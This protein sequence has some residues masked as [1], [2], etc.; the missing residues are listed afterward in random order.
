MGK[1]C[2]SPRPPPPCSPAASLVSRRSVV[3]D[4]ARD[5]LGTMSASAEI[6][7]RRGLIRSARVV[8][9]TPLYPI[10]MADHVARLQ[11]LVKRGARRSYKGAGTVLQMTEMRFR[12]FAS[13]DHVAG[14]GK[15]G[16]AGMEGGMDARLLLDFW[17]K[18][19]APPQQQQQQQQQ[20]FDRCVMRAYV[21]ENV[22]AQQF[23]AGQVQQVL[24]ARAVADFGTDDG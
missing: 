17:V 12:S 20:P 21:A 9:A 11:A 15:A 4:D 3:R 13:A 2:P 6:V 10:D 23:T 22:P 14:A 18:S 24:A 16:G 5:A 1:P 7:A 19:A 8:P